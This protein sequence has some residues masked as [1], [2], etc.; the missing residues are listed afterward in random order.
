M[1][2]Q[3]SDALIVV[4]VQNDFLPG[5]ALGVPEGDRVIEPINRIM[6]LFDYVVGTRDWH[7]EE[8][9]HFNDYGGPWPY[10]CLQGTP[11][12]EFAPDLLTDHF[13]E[14]L[15]KGTHP[16]SHGYDAFEANDLA[17]RLRERGIKRVFV[18]GLAT[19]YCV[20]ATALAAA[21]AGFETI[22]LRDAVAAVNANP[23]DESDALSEMASHGVRFAK[24]TDLRSAA[25]A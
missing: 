10:H 20:R 21:D 15:S 11:G 7:P 24:T 18:S 25:R 17:H 1:D 2:V 9:P 22:L 4:D 14:V 8:H 3:R 6:P 5:G 12:A 23:S 16:S 19:D 13:D